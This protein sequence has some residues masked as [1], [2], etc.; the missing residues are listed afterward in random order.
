[1]CG[2]EVRQHKHARPSWPPQIT[3]SE[4]GYACGTEVRR[5]KHTW[6]NRPPLNSPQRR[7]RTWHRSPAAQTCTAKLA[8]PNSPQINPQRKR[9]RVWH[10][11]PAPKIRCAKSGPPHTPPGKPTKNKI[12]NINKLLKMIL[13]AGSNDCRPL[14]QHTVSYT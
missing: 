14:L 4:G 13:Y 11:S 7:L 10:R 8:P 12:K 6:P 9:L 3:H 5:H 1:M 2:T